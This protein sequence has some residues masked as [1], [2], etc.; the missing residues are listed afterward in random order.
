[1]AGFPDALPGDTVNWEIPN[2][3]HVI[4]GH[5]RAGERTG[6]CIPSRGIFFDAGIH[7]WN[8]PKAVFITH[9]HTDHSFALP[10]I[11][12]D[13][14]LKLNA[15]APVEAVFVIEQHLQATAQL[16]ACSTKNQVCII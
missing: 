6:F 14:D 12:A 3:G 13:L 15:Y 7:C 5:S 9:S 1:M 11:T 8:V 16:N 10:M 2:T 4:T